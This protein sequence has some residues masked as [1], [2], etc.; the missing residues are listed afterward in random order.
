MFASGLFYVCRRVGLTK[1]K[2]AQPNGRTLF[3]Q[4]I[5][6]NLRSLHLLSRPPERAQFARLD[7]QC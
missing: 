2:S 5:G 3:V 1:E 7:L 4:L 6:L